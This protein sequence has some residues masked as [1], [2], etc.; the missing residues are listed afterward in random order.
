[1]Y[2]YEH[3]RRSIR[4]PGYDYGATGEYFVTI[5]TAGKRPLFGRVAKH[6][7]Q[8][9]ELGNVVKNEIKNTGRLRRGISIPEYVIMP[10]HI[11][12]IIRFDFGR[13]GPAESAGRP[14]INRQDGDNCR[15]VMPTYAEATVG[16]HYAPTYRGFQSPSKN[17]GAVVRGL[18]SAV[19]KRI[20]ILK[21]DWAFTVWQRNYFEHIIRSDDEL[22]KISHYIRYNPIVAPES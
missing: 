13:G 11:H 22:Q 21:N 3:H 18:K 20:K 5:C 6:R 14:Q 10:D 15:G 7:V 4:L 19:T 8:L 9:N 1:M 12:L 17:L 2:H 16:R